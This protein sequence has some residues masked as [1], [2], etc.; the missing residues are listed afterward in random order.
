MK[1][2]FDALYNLYVQENV[3]VNPAPV[4]PTIASNTTVQPTKQAPTP[5]PTPAAATNNVPQMQDKDLFNLLQ[6]KLKD[7]QFKQAFAKWLQQSQTN[8]A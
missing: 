6:Q 8:A 3:P 2:S 5:Q 1:T 7:E 4:A